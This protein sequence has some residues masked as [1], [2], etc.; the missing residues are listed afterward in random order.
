MTVAENDEAQEEQP[1]GA[2]A[3]MLTYG[4]TVTLLVTFFVMLLTFSTPNDEDFGRFAAGLLPGGRQMALF[5]GVPGENN[6]A[7]DRRRLSAGR[8]DRDGA[9]KP[10]LNNE[11]ALDELTRHYPAIDVAQLRGLK[12]AL[13]IRIPLVELFGTDVKLVSEGERALDY[14]VKVARGRAYSIVVRAELG[15]GL[16]PAEREARSLARAAQVVQYLRQSPGKACQEVG[17]SDNVELGDSPLGE[18]QCE[19]IM[20]EV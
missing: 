14:A 12:G 6:L 1:G 19:I 2:P 5:A 13:L 4:D 16:P 7:P 17:L 20:L 18:G 8:L 9:E 15:S 10:P 11:S 3:W